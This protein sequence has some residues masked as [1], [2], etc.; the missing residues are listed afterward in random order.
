L[1]G[2]RWGQLVSGVQLGKAQ[3]LFPRVEKQEAI[4]RIEAM[5]NEELNPTPA[6]AATPAAAATPSGAA[7][8][9]RPTK[10]VSRILPKSKCALDKS[11]LPSALSA[12]TIIE[13]YRGHWYRDSPDLRRHRAVL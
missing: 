4:E 1:D 6:P 5:A 3:A 2:L 8:A 10:S 9:P 7:A 12:R 13:A 11:K